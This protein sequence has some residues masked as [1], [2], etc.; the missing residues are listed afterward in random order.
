MKQQCTDDSMQQALQAAALMQQ[1]ALAKATGLSL[2]LAGKAPGCSAKAVPV[3]PKASP[4][5]S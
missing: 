3:P 4:S 2:G 1:Q 5:A